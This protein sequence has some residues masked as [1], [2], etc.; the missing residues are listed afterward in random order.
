MIPKQVE[1]IKK[2]EVT[3]KTTMNTEI[4]SES[5]FPLS[6][7]LITGRIH[8]NVPIVVLKEIADSHGI[9]FDSWDDD[10][11][12][13][14]IGNMGNDFRNIRKLVDEINSHDV[15]GVIKPYKNHDY[16][17]I[18]RFINNS[19]DW[20]LHSLLEAFSF[21]QHYMSMGKNGHLELPREN[22]SWGRQTPQCP[23]SYNACLLYRLC[24]QE[25]I[26]MNSGTTLQQ[27]ASA[28]SL[29]S[30]PIKQLQS[31][32]QEKILEIPKSSIIR[33]LIEIQTSQLRLRQEKSS[34]KVY[35][36]DELMKIRQRYQ[37]TLFLR[38][39]IIP[40]TDEE[41]VVLAA[42]NY[43]IDLTMSDDPKGDY[44]ILKENNSGAKQRRWT[45]LRSNFNPLFPKSFYDLLD[46]R[47]M[48]LNEGFTAVDLLVSDPY[49]LLQLAYVSNNFY[50]GKRY[51][52]FIM[53]QQTPIDLDKVEDLHDDVVLCYG[54]LDISTGNRTLV[55]Y[56]Y[57]ELTETFSRLKNFSNPLSRSGEVFESRALKKLTNICLL[58][59]PHDTQETINERR[60][61]FDVIR[62]I[63]ILSHDNNQ[64]A[65]EFYEVYHQLD[66][67]T[68][69]RVRHVMHNLMELAMSLRGYLGSG[70]YPIRS[71]PVTN[72]AEVDIRVTD[73]LGI[74]EKSCRDLGN[75]GKSI[76]NLPLL[77]YRGAFQM[78]TDP[79]DGLTIGDRLQIIKHGDETDNISSCIR[80]SSNWLTASAYRYMQ[81]IGMTPSFNINDLINVS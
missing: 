75:I 26:Y 42:L 1:E 45:S 23:R 41:A 54:C 11:G 52:P 10:I 53:N 62:E 34:K 19:C 36:H 48:V 9:L 47:W 20:P 79:H 3:L 70:P 74:F 16:Q 33:T 28:V 2:D 78:S 43:H 31:L 64:K 46:L 27:M 77:R 51:S 37:D 7:L 58:T 73:T 40:Q 30:S 14:D 60:R 49:E 29:L 57:S 21:I 44:S 13:N 72:Q 39:K 6:R 61:L 22:F 50:H 15:V 56:R 4:S 63:E 69:E 35:I 71:A 55:A 76:L 67:L 68:K 80:L 24:L 65:R 8:E 66:E 32:L 18:A 38:R 5:P 17:Y 25:K 81:I 59:Y 12:D